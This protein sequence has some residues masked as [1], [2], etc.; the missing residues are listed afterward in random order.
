MPSLRTYTENTQDDEKDDFE[1][2][3]I[4]VVRDLEKDK[5]SRPERVHCL[6]DIEGLLQDS[7]KTHF[8]HGQCNSC[9]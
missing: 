3:P 1:E 4:T 8:T 9:N 5:F 2:M 6:R 7:N